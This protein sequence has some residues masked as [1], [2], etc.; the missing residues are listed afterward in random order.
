MKLHG[1]KVDY[2]LINFLPSALFFAYSILFYV[3]PSS[4]KTYVV[5]RDVHHLVMERAAPLFDI[6]PLDIRGIVIIEGLACHLLIYSG[7]A[8]VLI[9]RRRRDKTVVKASSVQRQWSTYWAVCS[10]LGGLIFLSTGGVINGHVFYKSLLPAYV[11]DLYCVLL[12]YAST[13][14]WLS[15]TLP[16]PGK[17][18]YQKSALDQELVGIK[19]RLLTQIMSDQQPFKL[20]DFSL[21]QLAALANMSTH[22]VSQVLNSGGV[23]FTDFVHR[24]RIEEARRILNSPRG[25]LIKVENL[26][27]EL[28]YRSKSAFF[29]SFRQLTLMTPS[30]FRQSLKS[31]PAG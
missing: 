1:Q 25:E 21:A 28:G 20:P 3:Q 31:V 14:F 7:A 4:Y 2:F 16:V 10:F 17:P 23:Q 18:K 19:L 9:I 29:T 8:I 27:Y 15:K 5:L 22:H 11:V 13:I 26:A 6:D 30:Q 24:Y 12:A